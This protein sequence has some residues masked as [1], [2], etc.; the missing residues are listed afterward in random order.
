MTCMDRGTNHPLTLVSAPAG[1]GKTVAVSTWA[2]ARRNSRTIVWMTLSGLDLRAGIPWDLVI[3]ELAR[4][5]VD[6]SAVAGGEPPSVAALAEAIARH[7]APVTLILDCSLDLSG[8]DA[9][10]LEQLL[11]DS[12]GGLRLVLL[13]RTD[14]LLPLHRYRQQQ[15]M[16]EIRM[17]DL[18]FTA[19]ET[20]DLFA[21]RGLE[22]S[23]EELGL[24]VTR[25]RGWAAGLVLTALAL[26]HAADRGQAVS[27]FI[28]GSAPIAEY[29]L[30]EVLDAQSPRA[31]DLLLRTSVAEILRPGLIDALA[32]RYA[33]AGL[34][35]LTSANAFVERV[36]G[37]LTWY[38]YHPLFRELLR[39]QI[40]YQ[41]P[42]ETQRLHLVA[43]D[44]LARAGQIAEAVQ[45]AVDAEL[46]AA[47][48]G[49]VVEQLAIADLLTPD[50]TVLSELLAPLPADI[51]GS[52]AALVRAALAVSGGRYEQAA[53]ELRRAESLPGTWTAATEA[54]AAMVTAVGA[55]LT[56]DAE[57]VLA[58]TAIAERSLT[59][60]GALAPSTRPGL[61]I[62]LDTANARARLAG[63][64]LSEAAD[65]CTRVVTGG[66]RAGF[67][68][69]HLECL[70]Y[71]ALIAA[72][73]G[74]NRKAVRLA[75]QAL[76]LRDRVTP[77]TAGAFSVAEAALAW[78]Y[79]E[80]DDRGRARRHA[81]AASADK[82]SV[83]AAALAVTLAIVESR[84]RRGQGDLR[85]ARAPLAECRRRNR[86]SEW[87]AARIAA[88]EAVI[89]GL[90]GQGSDGTQPA[91][92]S[93]ALPGTLPA[94]VERLLAEAH[95]RLGRG[96]E[97]AAVESLE[98]A[99][100]PAAPER[101][102]RPFRET[103]S[104]VRRLL[105]TR[106]DIAQ[107]HSWL[108][109]DADRLRRSA[110]AGPPP[111][112]RDSKPPERPL[113]ELLT[114]KE[115]E[116]LGYL[117]QLLTTEEIAGAMFVSVNTIRTHVRNILRKL[118]ASRR[119]Q[120]IRRARELGILEA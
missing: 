88:D 94:Q 57:A 60:A 20:R 107:R 81:A 51:P 110:R 47:A 7:R 97:D 39:A 35:E 25:T 79:V 75:R 56:D 120:A 30:A 102:R 55:S 41:D 95:D 105:R 42:D 12:K 28:R 48:A 43:A 4:A 16:A 44:W 91:V 109:A 98:L 63:G 14:A 72:W 33:T 106:R 117:A 8:V 86:L 71:L 37:H 111:E 52:A 93:P 116:V 67:E 1:T 118:G 15:L 36:P 70:G 9:A 73:R 24:I 84:L 11:S 2:R 114:D 76:A 19:D 108:G 113:P 17:A 22:L 62:V 74:E 64:P 85:G 65:A 38:H 34:A 90:E 92:A 100:R 49:Y 6:L 10:R 96:E 68:W 119:N 18:A 31:R 112:S 83:S 50:P 78:V 26:A 46:W 104:D 23:S 66:L 87:W 40:S 77:P 54:S 32:G 115:R 13:T 80:T 59:T 45:T 82:V 69:A 3:D 58:A 61:E 27:E 103:P 5:G 21:R 53:L 101:L 29:L 99:L 89:A